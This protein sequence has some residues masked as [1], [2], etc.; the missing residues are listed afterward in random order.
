MGRRNNK[1]KKKNS[2]ENILKKIGNGIRYF[3][4]K[5]DYYD[6]NLLAGVI[7]LICFGLVMLYSTSAYDAQLTFK[8]ND[9]WYLTRQAGYS[10]VAIGIAIFVSKCDY[11]WLEYWGFLL[12]VIA[13]FLMFLV[14][15]PL[16][17]EAYGARRWLK[18]GIQ[19]QPA[20]IGKIAVIVFIPLVIIKIGKNINTKLGVFVLLILGLIQA[21]AAW[22]LTDN[23]STG[24]IIGGI[25]CF[26]I[27]V[28]HPQTKIFLGIAGGLSVFVG[29]IV[30]W[31]GATMTTHENFRIRRILA[32]LHPEENLAD[33]GYQVQQALYAIGSGG[34]FGK[35]LGNSAQKLGTIPEAQNDMIFAIICEELGVFG[36]V[37]LLL[38]FGYVLYRLFFI[39]QNAPDLYGTLLVSG[40]FAH[41][42]LQ[43]ILNLCVVLNVIPTTG[44]GLPFISYG[45]SSACFLMVEIGLALSVAR[46]IK[47]KKPH[48]EMG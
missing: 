42:A 24:I 10:V 23:L 16:G 13:L 9:L 39:A 36:A 3:I 15:T 28:A 32:W 6:Y 46:T 8:G 41:F 44:I 26:L 7:L 19:F 17:V 34:F 48:K 45:G 5:S 33:G 20:E 29:A 2:E 31:M 47:F 37:L 30:A 38:L 11:H 18:L 43:V 40:V 14:I 27:F 12:Y 35:G 1:R 25:A 22:K 21:V 4:S